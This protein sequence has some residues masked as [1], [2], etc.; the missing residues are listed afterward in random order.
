MDLT[1]REYIEKYKEFERFIKK[2]SEI[3]NIPETFIATIITIESSWKPE[4]ETP[5][6]RGLMQVSK[7]A[8][9]DVNKAYGYNYTYEDMWEPEKN[10]MVGTAYLA[11]IRDRILP[12]DLPQELLYVS[13]AAAYNGG[14]YDMKKFYTN[15]ELPLSYGLKLHSTETLKYVFK[16]MLYYYRWTK[17][18]EGDLV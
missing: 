3:H 10:I 2:A 1:D 16:F 17:F 18:K 7:Y 13:M 9:E 8:V 15:F 14:P 4:A 5:W 11:L 12:K 6:A